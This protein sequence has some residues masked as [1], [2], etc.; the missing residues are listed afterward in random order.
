MGKGESILMPKSWTPHRWGE[1][2]PAPS[3]FKNVTAS[4]L[5]RSFATFNDTG[6]C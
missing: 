2:W 6:T 3:D 5:G 1:Y 4:S